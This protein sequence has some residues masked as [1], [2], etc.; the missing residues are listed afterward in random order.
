[1]QVDIEARAI[2][3]YFPVALGIQADASA[4]AQSLLKAVEE[5]EDF[6]GRWP[7]WLD[8]F[9]SDKSSLASQRKSEALDT[10]QPLLPTRVLGEIRENLPRNAICTIDTGN[11][12]LQAADRLAH[13]Q[14]PGLVTPL[15]FGLVGFAYA[16]ALGAQ[17]AEPN[18]PVIAVM[19]DGGFGFTMAEITSAVQHKLPVIAIVIDNGA[20][21]AEKA[22]QSEFFGGRL[23]GADIISPDY[24]AV[25]RL[26]GALGYSVSQPGDT[27]AALIDALAQNKPAV[28]HVKVDP[29]ALSALR[30]DLFKSNKSK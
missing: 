5:K 8:D 30:K 28:I 18:R 6:T 26:C 12:C 22:Y 16:A 9:K 10:S 21:G 3:R 1:V 24:A 27:A 19:G 11:A 7:I 15:D 29:K 2:G 17:A 23:L 14:C 4:F 13:F 25:A 20:W